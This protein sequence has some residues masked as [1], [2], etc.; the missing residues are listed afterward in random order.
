MNATE[1]AALLNESYAANGQP[2]PFGNLAALGKGVNW[3]DEV[4]KNT[5]IS[6]VTASIS[7]GG[8]KF[9]YYFGTS[10]RSRALP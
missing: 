8:E 6:D 10:Q 9:S 5:T 3:Q 4:F 7:G 1:Y 2:L